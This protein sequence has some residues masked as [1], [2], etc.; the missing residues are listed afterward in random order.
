MQN[1]SQIKVKCPLNR[2]SYHTKFGT[3]TSYYG[4]TYIQRAAA[5]RL[6]YHNYVSRTFLV[7]LPIEK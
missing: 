1:T 4:A 6:G 3:F 2:P 7:L 5:I